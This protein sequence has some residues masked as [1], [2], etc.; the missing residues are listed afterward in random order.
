VVAHLSVLTDGSFLKRCENVLAFGNPGS[1]K[2]LSL[3]NIPS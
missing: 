3:A 1:G 2:T